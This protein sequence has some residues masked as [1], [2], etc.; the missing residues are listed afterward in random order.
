MSTLKNYKC[1]IENLDCANCAKKIEDELNAQKDIERATVNFSTS[2]ITV[3]TTAKNPIDEIRKIALRIEP[4]VRIYEKPQKEKTKN[5]EVIRVA[6]SLFLFIMTYM[7]EKSVLK[8]SLLVL[9]YIILLYRTARNAI[10]RIFKS[11]L[12]DENA[13]VTLSAIGAFILGEHL[14]GFMVAF[15]YV[16]GKILEAKAIDHSR[17]EISDLL[18]LKIERANKI[19]GS[20]VE[21]VASETLKVG[22]ICLI[23]KGETIPADGIITKGSS[24]LDTSHL[25][26][27]SVPS[28]VKKG[29]TIL[30]G[31]INIGDPI[32]IKIIKEYHNSTAYKIFELTLNATDNKSKRETTITK[33]SKFYTPL[34]LISAI[35]VTSI[36]YFF[37]NITLQE[38]IYRG[39]SFLVISCPCAIAISIPLSYFAGIGAA[40]NKNILVKGS[41]ILDEVNKCDCIMFDKTGTLTEGSSSIKKIDIYD[42]NF[43]K[44]EILEIIAKGE[45]LSTHP[46]AK[47]ILNE[48]GKKVKS[49]DVQN[50]KEIEGKGISYKLSGQEVKVGSKSF[51]ETDKEGKMFLSIDDKIIA[52]IDIEDNLKHNAK[53]VVEELKQHNIKT[54]MATG[55]SDTFAKSIAD[56]CKIDEYRSELLPEDKYAFLEEVKIR[57]KVMYIG[58]GI[59]DA[60]SLVESDVGVSMGSIGSNSAIEVSDIVLM[61][62]DLSGIIS[63]I[64]IA[65]KTNKIITINLIFALGVKLTILVLSTLGYANMALAVFADTGVTLLTILNSLRILK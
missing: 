64:N 43:D 19:V 50:F 34:I 44:N 41:N 27:E 59:N 29:D 46:L 26:G 57:H 56:T 32:E 62:D 61:N 4:E 20:N 49:S 47:I 28:S 40:S 54:I 14:E 1:Y 3:D 45:S 11:H 2:T 17:K 53:K 23:R 9:S 60:P 30:S 35:I 21:S 38:S 39:L 37:F 36:L 33:I 65:K 24:F 58:D 63:L 5:H 8:T 15:L 31:S 22:D 25:T 6:I 55:D 12:I 42:K 52:S 18:D 48:Y 13:L 16:I 7:I 10:N 51:V